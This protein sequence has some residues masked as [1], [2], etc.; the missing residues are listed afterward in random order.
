MMTKKIKIIDKL[1]QN[2]YTFY[3]RMPNDGYWFTWFENYRPS[4]IVNE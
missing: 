3:G 2:I 4:I 1:Y